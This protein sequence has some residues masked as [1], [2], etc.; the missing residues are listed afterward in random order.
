MEYIEDISIDRKHNSKK[1]S[2]IE[3]GEFV[4]ITDEYPIVVVNEGNTLIKVKNEP[5]YADTYKAGLMYKLGYDIEPG[6]YKINDG[7]VRLYENYYNNK[8][9]YVCNAYTYGYIDITEDVDYIR[10]EPRAELVKAE[11]NPEIKNRL[12]EGSY[13]IGYNAEP[14]TYTVGSNFYSGIFDDVYYKENIKYEFSE[15]GVKEGDT[16]ELSL[17]EPYIMVEGYYLQKQ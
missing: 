12:D 16:V 9:S 7:N 8:D 4:K 6:L 2:D 15:Y 10:L 13:I 14:G 17:D 3:S 11:K 5:D 1:D